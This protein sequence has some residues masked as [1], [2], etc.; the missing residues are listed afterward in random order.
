MILQVPT[1]LFFSA[2]IADPAV[3]IAPMARMLAARRFR[4]RDVMA[5]LSDLGVD[6]RRKA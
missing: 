2:A 3:P 5:F 4:K 1:T 6:E